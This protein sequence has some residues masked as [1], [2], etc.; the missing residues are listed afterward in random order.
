MNWIIPVL[1]ILLI[2]GGFALIIR[3][4]KNDRKPISPLEARR[5][6]P[7]DSEEDFSPPENTPDNSEDIKSEGSVSKTELLEKVAT[8]DVI[9]FSPNPTSIPID[10]FSVEGTG[11]LHGQDIH[12]NKAEK[13]A[14]F[15]FNDN[16]FLLIN[17]GKYL[18]IKFGE[19]WYCFDE[20]IVLG[21]NEANLFNRYGDEFNEKG[22]IPGLVKFTW[23]DW[24]LTV[25]GAS[26]AEY[27][28]QTGS[29]HI[30]NETRVKLMLGD[31]S[32]G[33]VFY[34]ENL[35]TGTDRFWVGVC[36]GV[37]LDQNLGIVLNKN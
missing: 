5:F 30:P 32:D 20:D 11:V 17:L 13:T 10:Q 7:S 8:G 35:R 19:G 23:R 34:M 18:L 29:C 2:V 37:D 9:E 1:G 27:Y 12:V 33:K 28:D 21:N 6:A 4:L 31:R 25:N 3:I 14:E 24:E 15:T 22:R 36:L 16:L 26:Y